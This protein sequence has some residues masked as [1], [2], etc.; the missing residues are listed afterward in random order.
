MLL[1]RNC[2]EEID[3]SFSSIAD[4]NTLAACRT[5]AGSPIAIALRVAPPPEASRVCVQLPGD[6]AVSH[7]EVIASHGDSVLIAVSLKNDRVDLLVYNAGSVSADDPSRPPSLLLLPPFYP[8]ISEAQKKFLQRWGIGPQ[9]RSLY[10]DSTGL[11]RRGKD[12]IVVAQLEVE[13]VEDRDNPRRLRPVA[14]LVMFRSGEWSQTRP[15]FSHGT[16]DLK[17]VSWLTTTVVAVGDRTLCWSDRYNGAI[18]SDVLDENPTLRYVPFPVTSRYRFAVCATAG[19]SG[20]HTVKLVNIF[21][22]CRCGDDGDGWSSDEG[23]N[24]CHCS[25]DTYTIRTWMLKMDDLTWVKDG[26]IDAS[27]LWALDAGLPRYYPMSYPVVS[28]DNPDTITFQMCE[29][30][31]DGDDETAWL[32]MLDMR[33]KLI[34]AVSVYTADPLCIHSESL[35]PSRVSGYMNSSF[36]HSNGDGTSSSAS[37]VHTETASPQCLDGV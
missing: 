21:P 30:K 12:E 6:T 29:A 14:E 24:Q 27:E 20:G 26:T 28:L 23:Y 1:E 32:V 3:G 34:P 35:I 4:H 2:V 22:H 9:P 11:L 36:C 16:D 13:K 5:S 31:R 33:R 8:P 15:P 18:F 10:T 17:D 37:K 19:A 7:S 25:I